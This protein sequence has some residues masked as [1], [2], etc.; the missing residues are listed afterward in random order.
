MESNG[1]AFVW[2]ERIYAIGCL[3]RAED[4]VNAAGTDLMHLT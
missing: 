4:M 3:I 2:L 1:D